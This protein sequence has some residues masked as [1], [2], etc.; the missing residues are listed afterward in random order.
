M[1]LRQQIIFC[2]VL[3]QPA[4]SICMQ[5]E[6]FTLFKNIQNKKNKA[7]VIYTLIETPEELKNFF[8]VPKKKF[9]LPIQSFEEIQKKYKELL[10]NKKN[11][12]QLRNCRTLLP[13]TSDNVIVPK[14]PQTKTNA[15][16]TQKHPGKT[17]TQRYQNF[18][19][20]LCKKLNIRETIQLKNYLDNIIWDIRHRNKIYLLEDFYY[21][22]N[23]NLLAGPL[24]TAW[25]YIYSNF[26]RR[27][28]F[29]KI[30]YASII[31]KDLTLFVDPS[32]LYYNHAHEPTNSD[33]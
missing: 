7:I 1:K 24:N 5:D 18:C 32:F 22:N 28:T 6:V 12:L 19:R 15:I 2:I 8:F 10:Q 31:N 17:R 30:P 11:S 27:F 25:F 21:D 9:T 14:K 16:N 29:N 33:N 4:L 20:I 26:K 3:L 23:C 13:T